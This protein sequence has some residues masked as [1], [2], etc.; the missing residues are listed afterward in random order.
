MKKTLLLVS[1]ALLAGTFTFAQQGDGG[2]PRTQLST[3]KAINFEHRQFAKPDLAALKAEDLINDEQKT[4]PWRFGHNH[5]T[6]LNLQNSGTWTALAN[7]GAIWQLALTCEGALTVNLTFENTVIPE[8]NELFVFNPEKDFI[9][10]SFKQYHTYEGQLGTELVPGN[11]AIVEYYVAPENMNNMGSLTVGTVTHGYRTASE[12]MEKAFGSSGNCN[13]NVAC[14]DGIP[15]ENQIRAT[16]MLVSGS[17]GFCTGSMINNTLNDA[18]PYVLTANHCY[19]NPANWIFRFNWQSANCSNPGSSPSFVSLSGAT[20]RSRRTPSDFCLVEITGGLV[21]GTVPDAYNTYFPGWDNSDTPPTSAVCV[22]HPSG[23]I[24]KISFDDNAL[25]SANGMGSAEANSQWR[26]VWDRSTT[27]EPGS[28]GSPLFDQNGRIVGQLW[29]GGASCSNLSSPD[30]YGKVSYSW[31]PAGSNSTNQLKFWLDPNSAGNTVLDGFD[32]ISNCLS[33]YTYSVTPELCF[34][35]DDGAVTVSFTGGNSSGATFNIGTGPQASGTFS[36]LSQGTYTVV[37][38][39]GD[40][41]PTNVTVNISGPS[42][43][44][45]GGGVTNETVA[46]NGAVNLT[47][48]GG[49]SPFTYAWS[50]PGSFSATTEDI[51]GLAGGTY[52]VTVTDANGCTT[53]TNFTVNS[54]VGLVDLDLVNFNL[55]PNPSNGVF[56]VVMDN[57]DKGMYAIEVTDLDG[58]VVYTASMNG[59]SHTIDLGAKANGTYM[60]QVSN[61]KSRTIKRI[62]LKK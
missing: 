35:D 39:D 43:L 18:T 13:M 47:V 41:C 20:L 61:E 36:G 2:N 53:T 50:G 14:P 34:G 3:A 48:F 10:G 51:S 8:G 55:Y 44:T 52:T 57:A 11:T 6:D 26:L 45:T 23:D 37:V 42:Q 32:P 31:T 29:G 1:F 12:Y 54:V 15:Y 62:V 27:T 16:V 49:T 24:K 21:N 19:S 22:H 30:Y 38:I 7:G 33:T 60:L 59:D 58:R 5:Y 9:L 40:A 46:N 17:S 4:G 25:T 56:N 28:S